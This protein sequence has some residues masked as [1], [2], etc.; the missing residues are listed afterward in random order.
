MHG[1]LCVNTR[2]LLFF[3]LLAGVPLA[4][5]G[6]QDNLNFEPLPP[7]RCPIVEPLRHVTP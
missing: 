5:R 3:L 7:Y 6:Q 1:R 4:S 2:L